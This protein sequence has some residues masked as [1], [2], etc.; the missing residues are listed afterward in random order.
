MPQEIYAQQKHNKQQVMQ[1]I[2]VLLC[3]MCTFALFNCFLL[4]F[5][6]DFLLTSKQ[7]ETEI[8]SILI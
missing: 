2:N 1:K 3:S 7:P 8:T 5:L 6:L 4:G